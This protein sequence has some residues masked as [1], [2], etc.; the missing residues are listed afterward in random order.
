MAETAAL[1]PMDIDSTLKRKRKERSWSWQDEVEEDE[2]EE[3]S[4]SKNS[5]DV[6]KYYPLPVTGYESA[7]VSE[8]LIDLS[9]E[10]ITRLLTSLLAQGF[11]SLTINQ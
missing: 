3:K 11:L 5:N 8:P 1:C 6:E 4:V 10:E 2:R 7:A 9:A